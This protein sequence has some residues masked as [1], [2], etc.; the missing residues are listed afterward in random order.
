[1]EPTIRLVT[2]HARLGLTNL[3]LEVFQQSESWMQMYSTTT[4]DI[5]CVCICI[6][7]TS[8]EV[9]TQIFTWSNYLHGEIFIAICAPMGWYVDTIET[10]VS[11]MDI[12]IASS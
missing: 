11:C 4:S 3:K 5:L 6:L 10:A 2:P 9:A 12:F 1:M 8:M 7:T